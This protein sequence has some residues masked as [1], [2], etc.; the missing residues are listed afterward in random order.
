M[1]FP[2]I[3]LV[4]NFMSGRGRA[5]RAQDNTQSAEPIAIINEKTARRFWPS[6]PVGQN[7]IGQHLIF[8]GSSKPVEIVGIVGDVH[9]YDLATDAGLEVYIPCAFMPPQTGNLA[10]KTV[11][12]PMRMAEAIRA[13]VHAIDANQPVSHLCAMEGALGQSIGQQRI[14]V[15]LLGFFA[16]LALLLAVVGLYGVMAYSVAQRIPELSIRRALGAQASD[17][18]LMVTGQ[19]LRLASI[20]IVFGLVGAICLTR[21]MNGVLFHVNAIDPV[22]FFVVSALFIVVA[23]AASC[24][25]GYRAIR[26]EPVGVI[27]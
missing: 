17:I 16:G 13:T 2:S 15:L 8:G 11:G 26:I 6:Y 7:P 14:N 5:F 1:S 20:G 25:P 27:R 24:I 3:I 19:G 4:T 10:V 9:E 22:T 18:L 12:D 21:V 23:V